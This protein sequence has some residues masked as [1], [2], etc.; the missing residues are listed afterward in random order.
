[1]LAL[2]QI[3]A[4]ISSWPKISVHPHRFGGREFRLGHAEVGHLHSDGTLDISFPRA[5]HDALLEEH[6]AEQHH[7]IP[8]SGW[9]T[10]HVRGGKDLAHALWF[11]R[12]SYLRYVLRS[13]ADPGKLLDQE[14]A[15][16]RLSPRFASLLQRFAAVNS[17]SS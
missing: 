10:F 16:L 13:A 5:I 2:R 12:L 6:L 9:T 1:M 7:W 11:M 15:A 8:D 14:N 3:E 17:R 4:E